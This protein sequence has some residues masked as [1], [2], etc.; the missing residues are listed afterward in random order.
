MTSEDTLKK[1][2]EENGLSIE[3]L[4]KEYITKRFRFGPSK[5]YKSNMMVTLPLKIKLE[6]NEFQ[7]VEI[8]MFILECKGLPLLCGKD[9]LEDWN[10]SMNMRDGL[11]NFI[12][13]GEM[14]FC[15]KNDHHY[16]LA[17]YPI[18]QVEIGIK[19]DE[20][21]L[22]V[23]NKISSEILK[24]RNILKGFRE[25]MLENDE[26]CENIE[27]DSDETSTKDECIKK[28]DDEKYQFSEPMITMCESV[29]VFMTVVAANFF[30]LAYVSLETMTREPLNEDEGLLKS[31]RNKQNRIKTEDDRRF[32][33]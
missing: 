8:K 26:C 17:L 20:I 14:A 32:W 23:P 29:K 10:I 2:L 28:E 27:E 22:Y 21:E 11:I 31:L 13:K 4:E 6:N 9:T 7:N 19:K 1:Y 15:E 5:V 30:D 33:Q 3:C 18:T 12:N 16:V 25:K 24:I